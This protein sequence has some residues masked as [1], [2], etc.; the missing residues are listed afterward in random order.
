MVSAICR[1]RDEQSPADSGRRFAPFPLVVV[2]KKSRQ[3]KEANSGEM[4]DLVVDMDYSCSD[5]IAAGDSSL[6]PEHSIVVASRSHCTMRLEHCF[7]GIDLHGLWVA[8]AGTAAGVAAVAA[9]ATVQAA[10]RRW[11]AYS[12]VQ[13]AACSAAAFAA[14]RAAARHIAIAAAASDAAAPDAAAAAAVVVMN[15]TAADVVAVAPRE[16]MEPAFPAHVHAC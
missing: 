12:A 9:A 16:H 3:G 7:A 1:K 13:N 4:V 14:A 5:T 8:A 10:E 11:A 15:P 6:M 2:H